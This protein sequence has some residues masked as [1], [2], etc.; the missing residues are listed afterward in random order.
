MVG[1]PMKKIPES[2]ELNEDDIKAAITMWL[3]EQ[4]QDD[5]PDIESQFEITFKTETEQVYPNTGPFG[6]MSDPVEVV[7]V[8]AV[9]VKED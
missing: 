3:D 7:I 2:Y 8:S 5:D 1:E 9:A 4:G 6:G